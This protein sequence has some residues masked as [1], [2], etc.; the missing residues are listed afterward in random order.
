MRKPTV[1]G[2]VWAYIGAALGGTVSIAANVAHSYVPPADA[3]AAWTPQTGAVVGAIFWPVALFVVTEILAR[4]VW[5]SGKGWMA[6]RFGGLLPVALVAALVSYKHL[7]G[8]L[9]FYGEDAVTAH[10]GPLAVDGLMVMATGALLATAR[11]TTEPIVPAV[12]KVT[13]PVASTVPVSA[14]AP[15]P[16]AAVPEVKKTATP[17]VMPRPAS[18]ENVAKA[19]AKLPGATIAEIAA[20][21]GVSVSTARRHLPAQR[22]TDA[23]PFAPVAAETPALAA[24]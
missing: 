15:V 14:V 13:A 8:L 24:A 11:R 16:V 17:R 22:V 4:V 7:A 10:L 2:R 20:R 23:S 1:S 21:A 5:P 9:R 19:A 3:P 18:A 12:A 6:I